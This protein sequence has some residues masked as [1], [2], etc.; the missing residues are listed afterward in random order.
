MITG[1]TGNVENASLTT[2][3]TW[4]NRRPLARH[5][6]DVTRISANR[7]GGDG[8]RGTNSEVSATAE[9]PV[10]LVDPQEISKPAAG[11]VTGR[12][13]RGDSILLGA[14]RAWKVDPWEVERDL[15][16]KPP[17]LARQFEFEGRVWRETTLLR[18][19]RCAAA[20]GVDSWCTPSRRRTSTGQNDAKT[21]KY[22]RARA[23][24]ML[25]GREARTRVAKLRD[26]RG[27][28]DSTYPAGPR[29]ESLH[30]RP[31][32]QKK[33]DVRDEIRFYE[34]TRDT[35]LRYRAHLKYAPY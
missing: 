19:T 22:E 3:G 32:S 21:A 28:G 31:E 10:V 16:Y 14:R 27:E 25:T 34:R 20:S 8:L 24:A 11:R 29:R 5:A 23:E 12:V 33:K 7:K 15:G 35:R 26:N 18:T 17:R 1:L 2:S 6:A 30:L 13:G 4:R 9:R